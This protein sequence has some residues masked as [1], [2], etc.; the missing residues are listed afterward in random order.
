MRI[1]TVV[2]S[3]LTAALCAAAFWADGSN[4]GGLVVSSAIV[5][6]AVFFHTRTVDGG[7]LQT[8]IAAVY[9][10]TVALGS[11][12]ALLIDKSFGSANSANLLQSSMAIPGVMLGWA[13]CTAFLR[14]NQAPQ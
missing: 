1:S 2:V 13:I 8:S 14:W 4:L 6:L 9:L 5:G 3:L 7:W 12:S 10:A 11:V